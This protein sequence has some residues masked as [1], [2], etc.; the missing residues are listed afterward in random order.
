MPRKTLEVTVEPKVLIWARESM[1]MDIQKVARRL[2]T[3]VDTVTKWE[4]GEKKP[5]LRILKELARFYKRPLAVFFCR[6]LLK[7]HLY[8]LIFGYY[9]SKKK[10][11]YLRKFGWLYEIPGAFDL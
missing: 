4:L 11:C 2:N 9:L 1:G 5:T 10:A 3:S 7:S 8:Q 6:L